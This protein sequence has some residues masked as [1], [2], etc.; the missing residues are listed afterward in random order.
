MVLVSYRPINTIV[1]VGLIVM[2][3]HFLQA[4]LCDILPRRGELHG[5][6]GLYHGVV[7]RGR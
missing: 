5:H 1:L 4:D 3:T 7:L 6:G 2:A